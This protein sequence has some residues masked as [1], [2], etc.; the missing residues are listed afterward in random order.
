MRAGILL[1]PLVKTNDTIQERKY[2]KT[3]ITGKRI[4]S[5]IAP[6]G[7]GTLHIGNYLGAVKQF[8]E[9]AK[10]NECFLQLATIHALTTIQDGKKLAHNSEELTRQELALLGDNPNVHFCYQSDIPYH[11]EL[12]SILNNVTPLG[13][14]KRAHAYKDKLA[15]DTEEDD[16]NLGLFNY[17]ILMAA[18]ILIYKA[19]LVPVGRD[20]KQH[21]EIT[22]DIA[23]RFNR[24]FKKQV[25][26]L[27]DPYIPQDVATIMGTDGKRKMSKSLGNI[28]SIFEPEEIIHKQV[29]STYTDPTRLH[30]T[31][32]GHIEGNMVFTYLDFFGQ[33]DKVDQMK[34]SYI[35]GQIADIEVKEYLYQSLIKFFEPARKRYEELKNNPELVKKILAKGAEKAK[36]VAGQTMKEVRETIGLKNA[37]SI[38]QTKKSTITIDDFSNVEVRVGKVEQAEHVEKSEKLIRLHVDFGDFGKRV[39]FTGVRTYGYTADDFTGKQFLFVVNL[40][41]RKMMGEES[42]G[43]ILAVDSIEGKPLFISGDNLPVGSAIR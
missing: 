40:E 18:D 7:D 38:E 14:L 29:M 10:T 33:K 4:Y 26:P 24:I 34:E 35:K 17:P 28:I 13:L 27:P 21:V 41:P 15:K 16:I 8:I 2:M 43:M 23:Q 20:Q 36:Q 5:A 6:S 1:R 11:T 30:P 25:F 31:D 3:V 37:Y 19:T 32:P 39:I 22:R 42:Q 9:L 12:Q